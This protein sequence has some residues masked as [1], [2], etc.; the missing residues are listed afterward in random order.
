MF[1]RQLWRYFDWSLLLVVI[2]LCIVGIGM[3]YSS[4]F[5]TIDLADYGMRQF[6]FM[7]VGLVALFIAAIFDYRHLEIFAPPAFIVFVVSLVAVELFGDT[8]D[9][10]SPALDQCRWDVDPTN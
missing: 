2:V 5:N 3:V 7:M 8:Q 4:T 1:D 9:T 10:G 6:Q